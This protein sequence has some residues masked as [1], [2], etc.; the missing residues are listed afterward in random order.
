MADPID[1]DDKLA[2][3][4]SS[5]WREERVS[6]PHPDL[7]RS[8]IAGSLE[9]GAMEFLAFHLGDCACPYCNAVIEDLRARDDEAAEQKLVDLRDRLLRSTA[10]ALKPPP[11]A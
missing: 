5:V 1:P 9:A 7:L 3:T 4:V 6:C 10:A 11:G 2:F 8:Y